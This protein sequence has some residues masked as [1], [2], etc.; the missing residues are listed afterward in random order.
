R[1]DC[2]KIAVAAFVIWSATLLLRP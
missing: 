1:G 2:W